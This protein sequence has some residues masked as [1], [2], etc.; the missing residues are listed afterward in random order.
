LRSGA[1][2]GLATAGG[3]Q[4]AHHGDLLG[5]EVTADVKSKRAP[6]Q[7]DCAPA[8]QAAILARKSK[9]SAIAAAITIIAAPAFDR[10]GIRL[11]G[12]FDALIGD[13]LLVQATRQPLLDGACALLDLGADPDAGVVLQPAGSDTVSLRA[14]VG[15]AAKLT[16]AERAYGNAPQF[17]RWT[18]GPLSGGEAPVA[19][20][21][22]GVAGEPRGGR[23]MPPMR[24]QAMTRRIT[25]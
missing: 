4:E 22:E 7:H 23:L 17:E 19:Q 6:L 11:H 15:V 3:Q 13:R 18:P 12:K 2:A 25:V 20:I 8:V 21:D 9:S 1:A 16:V 5:G 14:K 10:D 24:P